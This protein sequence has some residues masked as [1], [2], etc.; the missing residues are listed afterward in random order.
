M[1][2]HKAD[3]AIV[4]EPRTLIYHFTEAWNGLKSISWQDRSPGGAQKEGSCYSIWLKFYSK[5]PGKIIPKIERN[6]P[7][8]RDL[9]NE[10]RDYKG[11]TQPSTVAG[12]VVLKI[13]KEMVP[14][15]KY[16]DIIKIRD[17]I[18]ELSQEDK[19]FK[20]TFKVMDESVMKDGYVHEPMEMDINHRL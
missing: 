20:C 7:Y 8:Y 9:I 3:A 1:K 5:D 4:G 15:I 6:P 10:L 13:D 17:I 12:D 11:R 18:D 14:G 2:G 16:G 19:N